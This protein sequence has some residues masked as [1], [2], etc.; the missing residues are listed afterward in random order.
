M[1]CKV[2]ITERFFWKHFVAAIAAFS[3][4]ATLLTVLFDLDCIKNSWMGGI[5][6]F[7]VLLLSLIYASW[8]TRNKKKITLT[9]S[10]ELKLTICE[11]D[12]FQQRGVICIPFNEYFDTHVGDGVVG[13]ETLHGLFINRYFKD[14]TIELREKIE[15]GLSNTECKYGNRRLDICPIKKYPLGTCVD[16]RD[17]ENLYVLFALTHFNHNDVATIR[18]DEYA[19]VVRKLMGHL[20]GVVEGRPVYMPLFGTGLS[21]M[22]RTPQRILLHLVDCLDFDDIHSIP[23]GVNIVIKSLS[24]INVNLTIVENIVKKGITEIE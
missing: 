5:G 1:R 17:G 15:N 3:A 16:I 14:R 6:A 21:R 2:K 19:N 11:G 23:G 13:E 18:R 20:A 12:L 8:Q 24:H 9:L 10:S 4:T 7:F 22:R